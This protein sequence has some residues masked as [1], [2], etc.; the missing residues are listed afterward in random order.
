MNSNM[1]MLPRFLRFAGILSTALLTLAWSADK[2]VADFQKAKTAFETRHWPEAEAELSRIWNQTPP[3]AL[4]DEAAALLVDVYLHEEKLDQAEAVVLRFK[5]LY[6][7]SPQISRI[8]YDQGLLSLRKGSNGEAAKAFS[9]AV[10]QAHTQ[11][12]YDAA[13]QAMRR[14]V[15]GDGLLPDQLEAAYQSLQQDPQLGPLLR[16]KLDSFKSTSSNGRTVLIMAPVSGEFAEVGR[17]QREGIS[18][19]FEEEKA[20]GVSMPTVKILDDQGSLVQGV[21][22]LRKML[23]ENRVDAILGPAMSDVAAGV[24]IE[25]SASKNSIPLITPTATTD[26]IASLGDGVFQLNVTTHVLGQRIAGYASDCLGLKSFIIIAPHS[27]YGFQLAEAF[28]E[29]VRK[30]GGSVAGV[31]YVDPDAANITEPLQEL[32]QKVAGLYFEKMKREG[33]AYPDARQVRAYMSDSSL[34]IDGIF[35]PASSADEADKLASQIVFNKIRGQMLGSSGWYDKN[36][37]MKSSEASQGAYFSV[38]F[39]DQPRTEI[40]TA[41]AKA[42]RNRWHRSPDRVAALSYDAAR[43][44]L[45]GM[46]KSSQ[47]GTLIPALR[48]INV[49]PGVLGNIVF[50]E[51]GVNQNTALFR[52]EHRTFREVQDCSH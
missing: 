33:R 41:F 51:E 28:A 32:R 46:E 23:H 38:D 35:V 24:A 26:G 7:T 34:S 49:F 14:M 48:G 40:Y 2:D 50:G 3:S 42:Y 21:R 52:L 5:R 15:E 4:A 44:L 47:P 10:L 36:L 19:A 37:L 8:A 31:I 39:Q 43:F 20:R 45:Q 30:K 29:T 16:A 27:E 17:S 11:S 25:L 9:F 6:N 1:N 12:L 18:L 13:S 22:Q